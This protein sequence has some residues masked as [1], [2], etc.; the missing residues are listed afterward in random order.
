MESNRLTAAQMRAEILGAVNAF[1]EREEEFSD[2]VQLQI[3]THTLDMTIADPENDLPECDYYPMMDLVQAST[4][5]PGEWVP[6]MD[7]ID[8][9]VADYLTE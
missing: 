7:A 5:A 8:S 4:E 1:I 6:D 2:N 9:V 3:D